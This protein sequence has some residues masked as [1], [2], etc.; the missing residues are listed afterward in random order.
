MHREN[1]FHQP[2]DVEVGMDMS[3]RNLGMEYGKTHHEIGVALW[4]TKMP[5]LT[6]N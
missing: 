6:R 3:L 5:V 4:E 2:Q 1:V